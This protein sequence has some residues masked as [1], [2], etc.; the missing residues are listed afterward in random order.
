MSLLLVLFHSFNPKRYA[1]M[2]YLLLSGSPPDSVLLFKAISF[3]LLLANSACMVANVSC[4]AYLWLY[5]NYV[6]NKIHALVV[7]NKYPAKWSDNVS[8]GL[9]S[10]RASYLW[11]RTLWV[12]NTTAV[13]CQ[14]GCIYHS[15]SFFFS[16]TLLH[17]V[18]S[19]QVG[20]LNWSF[21][22]VAR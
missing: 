14:N 22:V 9:W 5:D 1:E 13:S 19:C 21:F 16:F 8:Y 3:S 10:S 11:M 4:Y 6:R 20:K 17:M 2:V 18:L 12:K 7:F 15:S